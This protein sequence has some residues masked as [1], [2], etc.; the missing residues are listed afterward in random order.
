MGS[1]TLIIASHKVTYYKYNKRVIKF[2]L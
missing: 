2:D 1:K